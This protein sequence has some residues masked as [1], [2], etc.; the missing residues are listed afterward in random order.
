[1]RP[2][3]LMREMYRVA[4]SGERQLAHAPIRRLASLRRSALDDPERA[5]Q[6]HADGELGALDD[7]NDLLYLLVGERRLLG[8]API[9]RTAHR[10]PAR[11]QLPAQLR[12]LDL[13]ARRAAAE[14]SAGAVADRAEGALHRCGAAGEDVAA[15]T[16]ASGDEYRLVGERARGPLA[17][18]AERAPTVLLELRHVVRDV[19]DLAG[20]C[21]DLAP[22]RA[23]D[24]PAHAVCDRV[25][26]GPGVVGRGGHRS[27]VGA[28]IG[29]VERRARELAVG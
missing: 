15:R 29:R 20:A 9:G 1:M 13:P 17:M 25:A 2:R 8:E 21:R 11:L 5:Q 19:V 4:G 16:H 3:A 14:R 12:A 18:D 10:D 24:R 22:E 26:V 7:R 27:E 28:A 6:R 23:L